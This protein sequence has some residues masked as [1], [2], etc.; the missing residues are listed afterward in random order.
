MFFYAKQDFPNIDLEQSFFVGDQAT[1]VLAAKAA[2][3][4][5]I[6]LLD[7]A[8]TDEMKL[9]MPGATIF[10]LLELKYLILEKG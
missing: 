8:P 2:G 3:I 7:R 6:A 9:A 5:S 1:D 4:Q 10:S